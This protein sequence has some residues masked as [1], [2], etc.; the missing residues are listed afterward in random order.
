MINHRT[1][2][3]HYL[4]IAWRNLLKYKTQ[5]IISILSLAVGVVCFAI[6]VYLLK[7]FVLEIYLS[8]MDTR[9]VSVGAYNMTEEQYKSRPVH[10][11]NWADI[12]YNDQVRID[13]SFVE[14]LNSLE[15]PSMREAR[16]SSM[17]MGADTGFETKDGKRKTLQCIYGYSSPRFFHYNFYTSAVTGKRI[18]ELHEG[19]VIITADISK[20]VY[21]KGADPRGLVIHSPLVDKPQLVITDV[22]ETADHLGDSF[23]GIFIVSSL[24]AEHYSSAEI[25]IELAPGATAAQ[26]QKELSSAMPEYYFTYR[27]NDFDWSDEGL[28]FVVLVFALLLLGC[29][30]LL[31]AVI[32]FMKMQLQLFS[33]RSRELA[34]RRT[35]GSRPRQLCTLLAMEIVIVFMFA[36][37]ATVV[38]TVLLSGYVLPIMYKIVGEMVFDLDAI[39]GISLW[40]IAC[41]LLVAL[42]VATVTVYRYLRKPVGLRV[43]RS[44]HPRTVGQSMMMSVQLGVS[45]ILILGVLGLFFVVSYNF[46][47][48]AAVLPDNPSAYRR[49]LVMYSNGQVITNIPDFDNRL[50][51]TGTVSHIS[52][53]Y[54]V[55]STS[56]TLDT[57]LLMH[58]VEP[59]NEGDGYD[60]SYTITD[61]ELFDNLGI[62]VLQDC[63]ADNRRYTTAVYVRTE[64][65]E[66]LR[67]KWG[68]KPL[69]D[70]TVRKLYNERSYTLIGYA[71][72]LQHYAYTAYNDYTPAYWI[73]D[74]EVDGIIENHSRK[75]H[76]IF[77]KDGKAG[78]CEDAIKA[79]YREAMPDD[80]ND[81]QISILYDSWFS[82]L[83]FMEFLGEL[84]LLLVSVSILS[85]VASV[86]SNIALE[87]RGRRKEVALRKIHGAKSRDIMRLFGAYYLRL[88]ATAAAFVTVIALM[89]IVLVNAYAETLSGTDWVI[90]CCYI[91]AA[92]LIV[93]FVTLATIGKKIYSV[94]RINAADVIKSE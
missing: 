91:L 31:I 94:S 60:Y 55:H 93:S 19:D 66:R 34:L 83:R 48:Q 53:T 39:Y 50:M 11:A 45:M 44:G 7:S 77:P 87:S 84:A 90:L 18:P 32:G 88:L 17:F 85:I 6:T 43:G 76:I 58:Y 89:L 24:P 37:I 12:Q 68:L 30:V 40:I 72:A 28:F 23:S 13:R 80:M 52:R 20:K 27:V 54:L 46:K 73:V 47:E 75:E 92:I 82:H 16:F 57:R 9:S 86:Y 78:R 5:N 21:G 25:G 29:S 63:P 69:P 14:R 35:M 74:G 70:E 51:Q 22:V 4:K 67:M 33:L 8:E 3:Q 36:A 26:L 2:I 61:E 1:M 42:S 41:T 79:M 65:A 10:D 49:A 64:E 15:I 62:K 56:P 71:K 38:I 81:V 59:E